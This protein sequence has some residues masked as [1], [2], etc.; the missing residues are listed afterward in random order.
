MT[1]EQAIQS[2]KNSPSSILT[3]EDVITLLTNIKPEAS[4]PRF[5]QEMADEVKNTVERILNNLDQDNFIDF[6]SAELSISYG[7]EVTV[8]GIDT[9]FSSVVR[10][11]DDE[12]DNLVEEEPVQDS[13]VAVPAEQEQQ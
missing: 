13:L 12:I 8:D 4:A 10:E 6:G 2:L 7:R 3:R 9:D 1:I 5:T 11:I